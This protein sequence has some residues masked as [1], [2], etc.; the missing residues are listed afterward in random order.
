MASKPHKKAWIEKGTKV[1]SGKFTL[2]ERDLEGAGSHI[3][4]L[5]P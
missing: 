4:L 1:L 2:K 3:I 5:I